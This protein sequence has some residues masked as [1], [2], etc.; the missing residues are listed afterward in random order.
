MGLEFDQRQV[1]PCDVES[2][3][4][5]DSADSAVIAKI[6]AH[7]RL[8]PVV[9]KSESE[10]ALEREL[11]QMTQRV[12]NQRISLEWYERRQGGRPPE[13]ATKLDDKHETCAATFRKLHLKIDE[14]NRLVETLRG[15]VKRYVDRYERG[16][17]VVS[18]PL[19]PTT[20]H[21]DATKAA[22]AE[23]K[24]TTQIY[25]EVTGAGGPGQDELVALKNRL[26]SME[27]EHVRLHGRL[28][29]EIA[30]N[31]SL[32]TTIRTVR[33]LISDQNDKARKRSDRL[34]TQSALWIKAL[35][36]D[37]AWAAGVDHGWMTQHRVIEGIREYVQGESE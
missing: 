12:A 19:A 29:D 3:V 16:D 22:V 11:A 4:N 1:D 32:R 17:V 33:S 20:P 30:H 37:S 28:L 18:M 24:R 7:F 23:W 26:A 10:V 13:P 21:S 14:L 31:E 25:R 2:D 34:K 36:E 15:N 27:R 9:R 8:N 35:E 5:P 6:I